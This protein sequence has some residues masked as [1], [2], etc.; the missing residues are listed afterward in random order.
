MS[1]H[2]L[3]LLAPNSYEIDL[4]NEVQNIDFGQRATKLLEVKVG[5]LK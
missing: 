2:S 4:S 1:C 5:G 3:G